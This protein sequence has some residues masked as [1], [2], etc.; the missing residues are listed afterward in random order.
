MAENEVLGKAEQRFHTVK[1]ELYPCGFEGL[2]DKW[3]ARVKTDKA[4]SI[5]DVCASAVQRG[6]FVMR[7]DQMR[8]AVEAYLHE[9]AYQ[10]ANGRTISNGYFSVSPKISG[11]FDSPNAKNL[12]PEKNKL[13]FTFRKRKCFFDLLGKIEVTIEGEVR[14]EAYINNLFD[15]ETGTV[16][17]RLTAGG[18]IQLSGQKI[19]VMGDD[20]AVG[21]YFI[22]SDGEGSREKFEGKFADNNPRKL[23]FIAP[24]LSPGDWK[25]EICTQFT[26]GSTVL[27][28][29]RIIRS[30]FELNV[31]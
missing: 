10:L 19:K 16:N 15:V 21:L 22:K 11:V 18:V 30:R 4:L 5:K 3:I 17:S 29:P 25:I 13:N 23:S 6:N 31:A 8:Q 24:P 7:E 1:A 14:D 27:K 12:D 2:K 26:N 20:P 9:A 28:T